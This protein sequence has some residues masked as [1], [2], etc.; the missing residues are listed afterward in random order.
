MTVPVSPYC[1]SAEVAML[2]PNLIGGA[3]D[4]EDGLTS[5]PKSTVDLFIQLVSGRIDAAL[6][7]AGYYIPLAAISGETWPGFQT[8]FLKLMTMTGVAGMLSRPQSVNPIGG[9]QPDRNLFKEQFNKDIS[10]IF[11]PRTRKSTLSFRAN[12]REGSAAEAVLSSLASP[13]T[14]DMAGYSDP[15]QN[16]GFASITRRLHEL[17]TLYEAS[18][19]AINYVDKIIGVA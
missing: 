16:E 4:F 1:S 9:N 10:S 5:I 19:V 12:Y 11:N 18:D 2:F 13:T 7:Q 3:T 6:S 17:Q 8:D 15:T 14:N